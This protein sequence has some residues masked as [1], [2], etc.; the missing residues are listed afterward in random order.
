MILVTGSEGFIGRNL[1]TKLKNEGKTVFEFDTKHYSPMQLFDLIDIKNFSV[2]YHLGAISNTTEENIDKLYDHNVKFSINLFR[3][4]IKYSI[5]V[6]YT[7][8]ASVYGNTMQF[9]KYQYNPLNYYAVTKHLIEM[10][11]LDNIDSFKHIN[12]LRLFNVYGL[13]ERKDDM[14]ISPIYRFT[15]QAKNGEHIKAFSNSHLTHRDFVCVEDVLRSMDYVSN[16]KSNNIF[17]VG[18][19]NPITFLDVARLISDKYYVPIRFIDMPD[20][21]R[22]KYQWYSRAREHLPISFKSVEDWL[23]EN[24]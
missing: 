24:D 6:V 7:S 2:I 19:S 5:P 1:V 20:K 21:L 14:S 15:Q 18:T 23:K 3:E 8:S 16:I 22:G 11:I 17:D 12:V 10:W 13:D 9:S 4:A